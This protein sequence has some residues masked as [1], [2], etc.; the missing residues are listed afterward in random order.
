MEHKYK[1][2]F[3]TRQIHAGHDKNTY[4]ALALRFI[5]PHICIWFCREGESISLEAQKSGFIYASG[6]PD[7]RITENCW[8]EA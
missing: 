1:Y 7:E 5:K 6:K 8:K 3:A 2:G 4:G